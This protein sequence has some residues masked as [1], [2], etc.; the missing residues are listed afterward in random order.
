MK[1][2][3]AFASILALAGLAGL[4][5]AE[6]SSRRSVADALADPAVRSSLSRIEGNAEK[7]GAALAGIGA[8][9]SPSGREHERAAAV[10]EM[11]RTAGLSDVSIDDVPNAVG[12]IPGRSG[13][14]LVF[15]STLDDLETVAEHQRRADGPPRVEGD[16]V[17][18]PGVNTSATTMAMIAAAEAFVRSGLRP[19]HDLV[20]AAVAQEETGLTGMRSVYA[21][22][23]DRAIGFVDIL[24]DGRSISYGAIGIHWWRVTASG[25]PG[26][27]LGGGLPNVNQG[28]G[29]AVDRI[30]SLPHPAREKDS[31]TV[32]NV[33]ILRSGAVFNHKPESGWFSLDIRSLDMAV[34]A[35]IEEAVRAVLKEVGAETG[36]A[37]QMDPFQ[38]TP[39]G[40]IPDAVNSPLVQTAAAVSRHLGF[41]PRLGNAGSS[42]M[43]IAIGGGTPAIGLGGER[44][45]RRGSPDEWAG[46]AA[47]VRSAKHV[48]LLAVTLGNAYV[49]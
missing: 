30:L 15:I 45:G 16:R 11:M 19:E 27:S 24:G 13:R 31:R 26:H 5:A 49:R 14:A 17:V 34:I 44:G 9:L 20:F 8:I 2:F 21:E 47:M 7:M 1:P 46:I 37:F 36:I 38:L 39:G 23:R 42:N 43:N 3:I 10:A 22:F 29:R 41:E 6:S 32:I 33:G 40:Q 25:P 18:G 35:A 4:T 48:F 28:L 12:R